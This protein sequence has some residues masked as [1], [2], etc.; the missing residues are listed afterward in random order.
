MILLYPFTLALTNIQCEHEVEH[1]AAT[2]EKHTQMSP[3]VARL[4]TLSVAKKHK[5]A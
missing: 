1:T 2:Q 3:H 5:G 4:R